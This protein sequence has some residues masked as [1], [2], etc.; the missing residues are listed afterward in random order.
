MSAVN[1]TALSKDSFRTLGSV[2]RFNDTVTVA[3]KNGNA[4]LISEVDY[5]ALEENR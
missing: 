2:V 5:N 1:T 3:S 4:V